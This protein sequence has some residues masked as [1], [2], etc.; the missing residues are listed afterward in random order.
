VILEGATDRR[1]GTGVGDTTL[2]LEPLEQRINSAM[3]APQRSNG[4]NRGHVVTR[5]PVSDRLHIVNND[6]SDVWFG[7][8]RIGLT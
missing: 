5:Y 3:I 1:S 4:I 6:S 8:K 7:G 2:L